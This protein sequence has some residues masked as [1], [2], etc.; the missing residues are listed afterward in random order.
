MDRE[1]PNYVFHHLHL[2]EWYEKWFEQLS[3]EQSRPNAVPGGLKCWHPA[4]GSQFVSSHLSD[5]YTFPSKLLIKVLSS[6]EP[7]IAPYAT[8]VQNLQALL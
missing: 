3:S 4:T 5:D 7:R 2:K 1:M 6:A 8:S